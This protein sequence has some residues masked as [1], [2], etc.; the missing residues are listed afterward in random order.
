MLVQKYTRL[1]MTEHRKVETGAQ[2]AEEGQALVNVKEGLETVVRPSTGAAGEVFAGVSLTRNT[3]PHVLPWVG[4]AVVPASLTVELPRLPISGQIM[5][6]LA[7]VKATIVAGVPAA[8]GE[9]QLVG[10][11]LSFHADQQGAEYFIQMAYEPTLAEAAQL[12]G[13]MP[14]GGISAQVQGVVGVVTRGDVATTFYDASADFQGA[15]QVKLGADGRFTVGGSGVTVPNAVVIT[16][17][18]AENTALVLRLNV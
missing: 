4:E 9:V 2:I 17:P 11:R 7:G 15:L 14:I 10:S 18:S 1:F 5:V 12:L 3:P 16:A 13:N 6:K 8:A